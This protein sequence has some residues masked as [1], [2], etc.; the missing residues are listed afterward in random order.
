M[1]I[2]TGFGDSGKTRLYGGQVVDKDHLRVETYGDLDE[3]NSLIGV[4]RTEQISASADAVLDRVQ[5]DIFVIS[6]D[7]ATA[8]P[9]ARKRLSR[10]IAGQDIRDIEADIDNFDGQNEPLQNFIL[11]GG[12]R[13]AAQLHL[14]R[15]VCR[16]AERALVRLMRE[17]EI[18]PAIEVYLNRLSDLFFVMARFANKEQGVNDIPW[19][20]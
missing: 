20:Q 3:L 13:A 17:T 7:L 5:N 14:A 15:T 2:Y 1:K 10:V 16:R 9:E 19:K 12:S 4:I 8:D 18:N 6:A 11:P